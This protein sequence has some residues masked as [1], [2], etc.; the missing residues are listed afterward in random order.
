MLLGSSSIE[1]H[2]LGVTFCAY[3]NH[4]TDN[5]EYVIVMLDDSKKNVEHTSEWKIKYINTDEEIDN[6]ESWINIFL[7][8][9]KQEF[10]KEGQYNVVA[11]NNYFKVYFFNIKKKNLRRYIDVLPMFNII[12]D[13]VSDS[14][15]V[16]ETEDVD[17]I[18][19]AYNYINNRQ[20]LLQSPQRKMKNRICLFPLNIVSEYIHP[21]YY[22]FNDDVVGGVFSNN[23]A[24][25]EI[26]HY[27]SNGYIAFS[28]TYNGVIYALFGYSK[29]DKEVTSI[30]D[31]EIL[32]AYKFSFNEKKRLIRVEVVMCDYIH[33]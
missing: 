23:I 8:F 16:K 22:L 4:L 20:R 7:P 1:H 17:L 33:E 6:R 21:P 3:E 19:Q 13:E 30:Y 32:N 24:T 31:T 29:G 2:Y 18:R 15:I 26:T 12:Y 28:K 27:N 10:F 9:E 14:T 11:N 25:E 5:I